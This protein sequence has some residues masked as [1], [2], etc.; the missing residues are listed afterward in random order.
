[1]GVP[2]VEREHR[3]AVCRRVRGHLGRHRLDRS[4][5]R[6]RR[7]R[8]TAAR[9]PQPAV[10]ADRQ[11]HACGQQPEPAT[12]KE[13]GQACGQPEPHEMAGQRR[14]DV[15]ERGEAVGD[16]EK[17]AQSGS[18]QH[19]QRQPSARR[20]SPASWRR[21]PQ[22]FHPIRL[23]AHLPKENHKHN[24]GKQEPCRRA[25]DR[26]VLA[27]RCGQASRAKAGHAL[28]NG[29]ASGLARAGR[30]K[31]REQAYGGVDRIYEHGAGLRAPA[32][33][34]GGAH[35]VR[36]GV[37]RIAGVRLADPAVLGH[38]GR[39]WHDHRRHRSARSSGP[40]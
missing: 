39:Y 35:R 4:R 32:S 14:D 29:A 12:R 19:Q 1:M 17:N 21:G 23:S 13:Q 27:N 6:C 16:D 26:A 3:E 31:P 15:G 22:H 2:G 11:R 8:M 20:G 38:A 40:S 36:A 10:Q 33:Q 18:G 28:T 37:R 25:T 34:L 9:E 5:L 24:R 30:G 7:W